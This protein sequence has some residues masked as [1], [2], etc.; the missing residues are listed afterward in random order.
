[1]SGDDDLFINETANSKNTSVMLHPE[2][3]TYS[4]PKTSLATWI[5]QKKRHMSTGGYYRSRDRALIGIWYFSL[6][7]F[8]VGLIAAFIL[9]LNLQVV[10]SMLAIRLA[11]QMIIYWKGLSK[12]GEK[13]LILLVPFFDLLSFFVYPL[14]AVSNLFVKTKSWK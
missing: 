13:D 11:V 8:W 4:K 1:M 10:V 7:F 5:W 3:F 9:K 6:F 14:L 12:L 2:S